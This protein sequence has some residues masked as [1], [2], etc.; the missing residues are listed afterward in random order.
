M[1]GR[2]WEDIEIG[3][4]QVLGRYA[5]TED[6]I[7]AQFAEHIE[8]SDEISFDRSALALRAR[9]RKTLHAITLSEAT[10]ALSPS[11]GHVGALADAQTPTRRLAITVSPPEQLLT[12]L[13]N[14]IDDAA[15]APAQA[16]GQAR[17]SPRAR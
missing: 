3:A 15:M 11:A 2:Y 13:I 1:S 10:L 16:R 17:E 9:R 12:R 5:F 14:Q 8:T 6:E 4:K 7:E